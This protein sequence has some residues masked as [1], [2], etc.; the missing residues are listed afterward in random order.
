MIKHQINTNNTPS[1]KQNPRRI[2][3]AQRQEVDDEIEGMLDN[4]IVRV[5]TSPWS[6]PIVVV[7]KRDHSIHLTS[8]TY[9]T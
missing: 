7:R 8:E 2:P 3:F 1:V 4:G 5:Y 6:S 9:M